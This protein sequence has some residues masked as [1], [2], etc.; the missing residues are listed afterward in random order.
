LID[1][2]AREGH[3]SFD[4]TCDHIQP[5]GDLPFGH[6]MCEH[7]KQNTNCLCWM[8]LLRLSP[9]NIIGHSNKR[10]GSDGLTVECYNHSVQAKH[11]THW[12]KQSDLTQIPKSW[13]NFNSLSN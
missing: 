3:L 6:C 1:F 13:N 7:C 11:L 4:A 8:C 9:L 12:Q 5:I 2:T 10:P